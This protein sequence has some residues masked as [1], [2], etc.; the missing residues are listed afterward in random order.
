MSD[1]SVNEQLIQEL[2]NQV[3]QLIDYLIT[4]CVLL[5]FSELFSLIPMNKLHS[6]GV[7]Q[8]I[9]NTFMPIIQG[10]IQFITHNM[11]KPSPLTLINPD[12][13]PS[14]STTAKIVV[15]ATAPTIGNTTAEIITEIAT[16]HV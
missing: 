14:K 4:A 11:G 3:A 9:Y 5:F 15:G 8:W 7:L 6:N 1:C 10:I 13:M 12:V 16:S 2:K